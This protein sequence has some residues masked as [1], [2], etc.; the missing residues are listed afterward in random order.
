MPMSKSAVLF[1]RRGFR[2]SDLATRHFFVDTALAFGYASLLFDPKFDQI[3]D[4][5]CA[6]D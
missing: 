1:W 3:C 5:I 6:E 2:F 4:N